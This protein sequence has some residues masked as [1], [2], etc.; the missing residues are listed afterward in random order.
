MANINLI[1]RFELAEGLTNA[2][3]DANKTAVE[4]FINGMLNGTSGYEASRKN[5]NLPSF[6]INISSPALNVTGDNTAYSLNAPIWSEIKDQ[7]NN[8]V[9]GR[10]TAPVTGLYQFSGIVG[11]DNILSTHTYGYASL[12]T[13]N[14]VYT[15]ASCN[16]YNMSGNGALILPFSILADM[17]AGDTADLSIAVYNGT[18]VVD[19]AASTYFT[20]H[21]VC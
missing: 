6:I 13:S 21:L 14:R 5:V 11:L 16:V 20:G 12:I 4:T 10:F 1:K 2:Q 7:G 17:D 15:F 9:N 3:E 8:M 18:K 19:L